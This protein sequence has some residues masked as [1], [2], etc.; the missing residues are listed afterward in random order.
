M[1]IC[2]I[3]YVC[4]IVYVCVLVSMLIIVCVS[5]NADC[6]RYVPELQPPTEVG[7]KKHHTQIAAAQ[8]SARLRAECLTR[9]QRLEVA[10]EV[11]DSLLIH[12]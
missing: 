5:D 2:V 3:V 10:K 4:F 1:L 8:T 6:H 12:G 7:Q 11:L 9:G